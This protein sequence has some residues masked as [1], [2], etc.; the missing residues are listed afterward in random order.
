MLCI[1]SPQGDA[2][3][4]QDFQNKARTKRRESYMHYL[5]S[6]GGYLGSMT[7]LERAAATMKVLPSSTTSRR[8][9]RDIL[10]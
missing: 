9:T 5:R 8:D 2:D 1:T 7:G 10:D 4:V 3:P 6:P